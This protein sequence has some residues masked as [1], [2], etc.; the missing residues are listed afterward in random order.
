M[1]NGIQRRL[2]LTKCARPA[3]KAVKPTLNQSRFQSTKTQA[4]DASSG[5]SSDPRAKEADRLIEDDFAILRKDYKTP[6]NPLVLAHGLLG[7][8]ELS[9]AGRFAPRVQYWR[10]I[11]DALLAKN[12]E[13]ITTQVPASASIEQRAVALLDDIRAKAQGKSVNIIAHS[14]GGLDARYLI[15]S[16]KPK[17]VEIKSLTTIATPHRGSSF[18]DFVFRELGDAKVSTVYKLLERL[19]IQSGAFAQLTTKYMQES[20]NPD[21]P[22]SPSVRYFSYGAQ[23]DPSIWSVFRFSH[24]MMEPI[25]GPNDG[26]VSVSSSK[27]DEEGYRGTLNGVSH[28]DLI[29]WYEPYSRP[30]AAKAYYLQDEPVEMVGCRNDF[31]PAKVRTQI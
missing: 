6:K 22:N 11:K 24:D 25:E 18:A 21:N 7:F 17:D 1:I 12:V 13:V 14:M 3:R 26:L 5:A 28:L 15:S 20:F 19:N 9:V 30:N 8:D 10:G 27:W 31:D 2:I 4:E 16:L 23:F 29:N